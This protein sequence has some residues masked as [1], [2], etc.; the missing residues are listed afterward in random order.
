M[1]GVVKE[2]TPVPP[3]KTVPPDGTSYQSIVAPATGVADRLTVPVP[4]L[5]PS[6]GLVGASGT[7]RLR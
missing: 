5:E 1:L 2:L 3:A 6:T 4:H 7:V